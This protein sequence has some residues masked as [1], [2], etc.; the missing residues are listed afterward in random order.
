MREKPPHCIIAD[1]NPTSGAVNPK[2]TVDVELVARVDVGVPIRFEFWATYTN[3]VGK[4]SGPYPHYFYCCVPDDCQMN[5][6]IHSD[7]KKR[8]RWSKDFFAITSKYDY[9]KFYGNIVFN[10]TSQTVE[11]K[12]LARPS[13]YDGGPDKFNLNIELYQGQVED[14]SGNGSTK[15]AWLP[16]T[17][18]PD[19]INP[20]NPP[21]VEDYDKFAFVP[22]IGGSNA[23]EATLARIADLQ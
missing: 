4:K 12:A 21:H 22:M 16:M 6:S 13:G 9:S 23:G 20:K 8:V 3:T 7:S 15:E 2:W 10:Q 17:L 18:D 1:G 19:V 5:F 14:P 11:L